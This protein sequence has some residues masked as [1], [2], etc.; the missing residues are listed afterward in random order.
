VEADGVEENVTVKK[1]FEKRS[2]LAVKNEFEESSR[3]ATG[4]SFAAGQNPAVLSAPIWEEGA[5]L[6]S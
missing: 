1:S 4:K 5:E 6:D 2:E 3:N